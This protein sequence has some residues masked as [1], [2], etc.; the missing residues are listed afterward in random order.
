MSHYLMRS[1][2]HYPNM[3]QYREPLFFNPFSD[4]QNPSISVTFNS[5]NRRS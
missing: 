1:S 4:C 3:F 2:K 5:A